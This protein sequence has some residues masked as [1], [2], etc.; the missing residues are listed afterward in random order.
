MKKLLKNLEGLPWIVRLLLVLFVGVYSNFLRL[1]RSLIKKNII[2][3]VLSAILL[4][5]GGFVVLWIVDIIC[6][7]L[8]K[9]LWWID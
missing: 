4:L 8:N 9:Q 6:V 1:L 2:G 7:A 5:C 3:V